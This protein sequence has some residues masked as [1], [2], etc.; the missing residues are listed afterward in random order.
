MFIK[1]EITADLLQRTVYISF[2][3]GKTTGATFW[4]F[5]AIVLGM[6]ELTEQELSE[7]LDRL[8]NQASCFLQEVIFEGYKVNS[9][10]LAANVGT[11]VP[12]LQTIGRIKER[13]KH[14][15]IKIIEVPPS[16]KYVAARWVRMKVPSKKAHMPD[17]QAAY[18]IGVYHLCYNKNLIKPKVL[19]S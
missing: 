8:E 17:W 4:D 2:D 19:D 1:I 16:K 11:D 18:L 3:P 9:W 5:R 10:Q 13:L 6:V 14:L 15:P 7:L 12:T